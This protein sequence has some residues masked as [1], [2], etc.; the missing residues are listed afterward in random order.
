MVPGT[1]ETLSTEKSEISIGGG[2]WG[3]DSTEKTIN[4][5]IENMSSGKCCEKRTADKEVMHGGACGASLEP[6]VK[7]GSFDKVTFD[8]AS[9]NL[10]IDLF[11]KRKQ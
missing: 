8:Q 5:Y 3:L 4:K 9:G 7:K 2:K 6:V 10:R 11:R 1:E